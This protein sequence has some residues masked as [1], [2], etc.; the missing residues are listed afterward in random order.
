MCNK[1]IMNK[2]EALDEKMELILHQMNH[3]PAIEASG[4]AVTHTSESSLLAAHTLEPSHLITQTSEST[5]CTAPALPDIPVPPSGQSP[6]LP[7]PLP[8]ITGTALPSSAIPKECLLP[9]AD[10]L[11]KHSNLRTESK[12]GK[13]AVKL[14]KECIFGESVMQQCTPRGFKQLPALPQQEVYFL[15]TTLYSQFSGFWS[16]PEK[17]EK[18]WLTVQEALGQS[19]KR[20]RYLLGDN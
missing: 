16:A 17:F 8:S 6:L 10:V 7:V 19:C 12:M 18:K 20:L 5:Q 2:M 11:S 9:V 4:S 3:V 13:L 14:A 1:A 15:K